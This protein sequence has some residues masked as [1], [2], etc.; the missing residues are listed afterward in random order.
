MKSFLEEKGLLDAEIWKVNEQ[1]LDVTL[2]FFEMALS[3]GDFSWKERNDIYQI[4]GGTM[5][6]MY[7]HI[8]N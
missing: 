6:S 8:E 4:I 5:K 7:K 2:D 1:V 3:D